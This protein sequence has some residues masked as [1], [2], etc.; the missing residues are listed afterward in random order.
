MKMHQVKLDTI[1]YK[2]WY[3]NQPIEWRNRM[4]EIRVEHE[5]Y[6]Q[7]QEQRAA[8]LEILNLQTARFLRSKGVLK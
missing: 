4:F 5:A 3:R 6:A 2:D 7:Y 1:P 8:K